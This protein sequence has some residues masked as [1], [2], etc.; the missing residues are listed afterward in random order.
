M[1]RLIA[2]GN[3]VG[4]KISCHHKAANLTSA[5]FDARGVMGN[6]FDDEKFMEACKKS[7][8]KNEYLDEVIINGIKIK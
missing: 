2:T 5:T 7:L 4:V 1:R 3:S 8:I 6:V